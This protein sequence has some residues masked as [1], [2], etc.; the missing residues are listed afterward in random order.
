MM[1]LTDTQH[2]MVAAYVKGELSDKALTDFEATLSN[3]AAL[4]EETLFQKSILS[5]LH[6]DVAAK[7]MKQAKIDNLLEDKTQHP[8]FEVIRN[9]MQQARMDNANK[10]KRI[11]RWWVGVAAACLIGTGIFFDYIRP[12]GGVNN[13]MAHW[14]VKFE[15]PDHS[16][17][18]NVNGVDNIEKD[19][20]TAEEQYATG[21]MDA[22]LT[23]L[24]LIDEDKLPDH[25]VLAKGKI[26][27]QLKNYEES[28][29]L[30]LRATESEET[31]VKDEAHAALGVVYLRLRKKEDAKKQFEQISTESIK[32]ETK[33]MMK[34]YL[35]FYPDFE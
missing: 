31:I 15:N 23:T 34:E 4:R 12:I 22:A 8:K 28:K 6:L 13:M 9:N 10:Q 5:A 35:W 26:Q 27:A 18:E 1:K 16:G 3:D 14:T 29:Q 17:F 7:A 11:R 32:E 33:L 25:I 19:I 20:K 30:L 21:E 2:D 24:N